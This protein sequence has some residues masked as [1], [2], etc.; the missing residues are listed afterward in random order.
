[1]ASAPQASLPLFYNDL[2]PLNVRDHGNWRARA[3]ATAK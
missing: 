1:M 3:A 2:V